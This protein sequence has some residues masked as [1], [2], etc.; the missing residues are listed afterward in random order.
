[1][2][3]SDD[4]APARPD[5]EEHRPEE[6]REERREDHRREERREDHR[7]EERREDHRREDH[8]RETRDRDRDRD[9]D[10][11]TET[12]RQRLEQL[13]PDLVKKTFAAGMGAVFQT[14]EGI[15]RI[16]RESLPEVAGYI[17]S[18]ADGAKDRV[19]DAKDRVFDV[20][21]R[22][23]REFL[24]N[25]NVAEEIAKILT[26]L[27]FEIKT[28]IRFIPNSERFTGAEPDVK[29]SVRL[30][31]TERDGKDRERDEDDDGGRRSKLR[32][33]QRDRDPGRDA[34]DGNNGGGG[35]GVGGGS[36][37]RDEDD[38]SGEK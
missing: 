30:K 36:L 24:S 29:A 13:V 12:L 7:R 18:S 26:T 34:R 27:S 23:T 32:F 37:D 15:R 17:A 28:E 35:S 38:N 4:D 11:L 10:S 9:G 5:R 33:W 31:R 21:A 20:I 8:R 3:A 1:M 2:A 19:N 14:E 16:A 6:R 22:E 25:L